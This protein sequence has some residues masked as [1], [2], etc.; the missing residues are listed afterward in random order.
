MACKDFAIFDDLDE[1]ELADVSSFLSQY[2]RALTMET[3]GMNKEEWLRYHKQH[4]PEE[5]LE[6]FLPGFQMPYGDMPKRGCQT[7]F[8]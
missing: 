8:R 4:A 2:G 7:T 6:I 5:T 1:K 3:T